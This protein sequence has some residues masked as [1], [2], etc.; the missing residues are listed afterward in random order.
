MELGLPMVSKTFVFA[1][2]RE[3]DDA[4]RGQEKL[5]VLLVRKELLESFD[6]STVDQLP[7]MHGSNAG[8]V[9]VRLNTIRHMAEALK[10]PASFGRILSLVSL[11]A[12]A[13]NTEPSSQVLD[14]ARG[15]G[16]LG[17]VAEGSGVSPDATLRA[18]P[19]VN[20]SLK[21]KYSVGDVEHALAVAGVAATAAAAVTGA[22]KRAGDLDFN[23]NLKLKEDADKDDD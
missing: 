11:S 13:G 15:W 22:M 3:C 23:L 18:A 19:L 17:P 12:P 21:K 6:W 8:N 1:L 14:E 4:W 20:D 5:R 10:H 2:T 16:H 9:S 7:Q